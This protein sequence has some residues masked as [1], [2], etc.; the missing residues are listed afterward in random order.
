MLFKAPPGD[1]SGRPPGRPPGGSPGG[2]L[3]SMGILQIYQAKNSREI[4]E[5]GDTPEFPDP[6]GRNKDAYCC[7]RRMLVPP[8]R[9]MCV[10]AYVS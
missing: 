10:F 4:N 9:S 7:R 1:P 6:Q 5:F 8:I 2:A 3:K